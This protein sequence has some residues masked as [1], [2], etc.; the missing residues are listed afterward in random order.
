M[1]V[2]F[3]ARVFVFPCLLCFFV[4]GIGQTPADSVLRKKRFLAAGVPVIFYTP[5]TR[6]GFGASAFS[7][8]NF[9]RDSA[10]APRSSVSLG[11]AY[12]QNKQVLSY[13]PYNLFINN[14][15]WQVYGE[16]AYNRYIYNF[17]GTGNNIPPDYLEKYGVEFPRVRFTCLKRISRWFYAGPRLVYD[18][19]TLYD[20]AEGGLLQTGSVKGSEGGTVAGPAAVFLADS[21]DH[22]YYPTKGT[23]AELVLFCNNRRTGSSFEYTRIAFDASRYFSRGDNVLALNFYTI[24][25]D[26]PLPFFQMG[27]LGG[28]KKMRGFYEGRYRDNN[29][30]VLQAEYRRKIWWWLGFTVFGS[31]GQVARTYDA[32]HNDYWR[33]TFGTG[34]RICP[35]KTQRVNLRVDL[36][37]GN[38]KVL[39][40]FTIGEAF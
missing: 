30:I 27:Q 36:A 18:W 12:T 22:V 15:A 16:F 1:N 2:L 14:R 32:F 19:F 31:L 29:L 35:D 24:Y 21:R 13:L 39:T 4:N 38:G 28:M 10:N 17:Y 33:N 11:F 34:L 7:L 26:S 3:S 5:E 23:W 8:F 20:L 37:V 6:F 40:Y 9:R 25:S